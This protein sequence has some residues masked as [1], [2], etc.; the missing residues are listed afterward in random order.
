MSDKKERPIPAG[1]E[2]LCPKTGTD[3]WMHRHILEEDEREMEE[4]LRKKREK[5]GIVYV[6]Y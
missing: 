4:I 2:G 5:E 3:D 6:S 1:G